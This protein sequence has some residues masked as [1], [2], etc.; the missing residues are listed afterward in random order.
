MAS[1]TIAHWVHGTNPDA[2]HGAI[3]VTRWVL[4]AGDFVLHGGMDR[5]NYAL[6]AFLARVGEQVELVT[7]S[8]DPGLSALPGV[9][10]HCVRRPLGSHLLGSWWLSQAGR[11]HARAAGAQVV[12]NGGNCPVPA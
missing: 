12:V 10:V 11:R 2:F 8:V 6:A 7:H 4:V 1:C 9:V 3:A 5:A